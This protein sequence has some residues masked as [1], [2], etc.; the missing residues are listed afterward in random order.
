[1]AHSRNKK[2]RFN[3]TDG[4]MGVIQVSRRG[5]GF[6]T[7]PEG[8]YFIPRGSIHGAMHGDMVEVVRMRRLEERRRN[9]AK[10]AAEGQ[11]D[12]LGSV[13]R[14]TER[15][16]TMVVGTLRYRDGLGV[17]TPSDER[18]CHDIFIDSRA[19]GV[20][21]ED[22]DVV[23][24]RLTTYPSRLEAAQGYIEE[25]VGRYDEQGMDIEVIIRRHKLETVF[26]A[27]ALEEAARLAA[28]GATVIG[29]NAVAGEAAT[30]IAAI[31]GAMVAPIDEYLPRRD[32]RERFVFTVDPFDARDFDDALSVDFI[33]GQMLLGVH[34]ADVSTFVAWDSSI[35]MDAR[36]R[37]TSVY[38]PD[39][40][41]P[42]LPPQLSDDLCSL[43]PNVD[44]LAFSC[45]MLMRSDGTVQGYELYPSVIRSRARLSYDEVQAFFDGDDT[46]A[47][48]VIQFDPELQNRLR[49][50]DRL[51]KKLIRR[52][53]ARGAIDFESVEAKVSL[54]DVGNPVAVTLR[55]KNDATSLVEEAMILTNEV[56]ADHM[57]THKAAMVYRIHE[58]PFQ[59]AL[60]QLLPTLHEFGLADQGAPQT[61][62]DIQRILDQSHGRPEYALISQ[63]LLRAMKRAV[64]APTFIG[65]FGLA[66][67]AYCHFTSPIR[68]YPDLLVHRLLK[69]QLAVEDVLRQ[70]QNAQTC[71]RSGLSEGSSSQANLASRSS[72]PTPAPVLA[73]PSMIRQLPWLCEHSSEMEREA[74]QASLE[75]TALKLCEFLAPCVGEHFTGIITGI[76]TYGFY[77]RE[78][79]TTAEGF[80]SRDD[81]PEDIIYDEARHRF[82]G[83]DSG[84][85]YRL[86]Q[87]IVVELRGVDLAQ[88]RLDFIVVQV[89]VKENGS[90]SYPT[91]RG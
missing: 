56:V 91:S 73:P 7:T 13:K 71:S 2:R 4:S 70:G 53:E 29:T 12:M 45:D 63:L 31:A 50:L 3:H 60:E 59:A 65:H 43:K 52:R 1:M 19:A 82:T 74:E 6:V 68:R 46:A 42:M 15:A 54:D 38:L 33:E 17:V 85:E 72:H 48:S 39:R 79:S 41:L 40:V 22:G 5:Y 32:L 20:L 88:A 69:Q 28:T 80:I 61:A 47:D 77:V 84:R 49:V 10:K 36:R 25:V 81:L 16:H 87:R 55:E 35:D 78:D 18:I 62:F 86:G 89:G 67:K 9:Q 34:I 14:V 24:V 37:A 51:A 75:A 64:Y 90:S 23:E 66:S 58:E 26:S 11:R 76:N 30:T 57:L 8:E 44:R 83:E 27:G 21:A